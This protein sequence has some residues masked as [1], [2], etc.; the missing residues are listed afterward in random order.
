MINEYLP[1]QNG[2]RG[3]FSLHPT[4]DCHSLCLRSDQ[5]GKL[6]YSVKNIIPYLFAESKYK[7]FSSSYSKPQVSSV[8]QDAEDFFMLSIP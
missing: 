3:D 5:L 7:P 2:R 1:F 4:V 6:Y 8:R